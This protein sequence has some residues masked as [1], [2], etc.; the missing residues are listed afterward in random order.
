MSERD[1]YRSFGRG[2]EYLSFAVKSLLLSLIF[3]AIFAIGI[4]AIIGSIVPDGTE[5]K[6]RMGE[7]KEKIIGELKKEKTKI[8]LKG[9][10]TT[11][12]YVH[13]KVSLIDQREGNIGDAIDE[14]ELAIG[15]LELHSAEKSVKQK[16]EARVRDL[17]RKLADA[18]TTQQDK[19]GTRFPR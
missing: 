8:R 12:P 17:Q 19:T 3:T 5:V 11:N 15:L 4:G 7:A 6:W 2:E 14:M 10:F 9:L 13:W 16:Y 18:N 1:T